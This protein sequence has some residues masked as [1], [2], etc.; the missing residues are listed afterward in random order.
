MSNKY[1]VKTNINFEDD[2]QFVVY[3][4]KIISYKKKLK[5]ALINTIDIEKAH[6][7]VNEKN[8]SKAAIFCNGTIQIYKE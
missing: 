7:Y 6:K 3:I 1:I 2:L 4:K 5:Q 8:A